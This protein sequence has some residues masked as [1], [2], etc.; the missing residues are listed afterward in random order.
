[1]ES[2]LLPV[3]ALRHWNDVTAEATTI[4]DLT[5]VI[6]GLSLQHRGSEKLTS[7]AFCSLYHRVIG[8]NVTDRQ[9]K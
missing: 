2:M 3:Q 1:M 4:V 9:Y 5:V 7:R 8:W 6:S